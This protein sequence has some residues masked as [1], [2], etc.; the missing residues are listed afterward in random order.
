MTIRKAPRPVKR[1]AAPAA[2]QAALPTLVDELSADQR[3]SL[4]L[5]ALRAHDDVPDQPGDRLARRAALAAYTHAEDEPDLAIAW[6]LERRWLPIARD[7]LREVLALG[8]AAFDLEGDR[9]PRIAHVLRDAM[10]Q[11]PELQTFESFVEQFAATESCQ[12]F[13][14]HGPAR[15][16]FATAWALRLALEIR[17]DKSPCP[18]LPDC[19]VEPIAM[20]LANRFT[21]REMSDG[22]VVV[23]GGREIGVLTPHQGASRDWLKKNVEQIASVHAHRLLRF[24][25]ASAWAQDAVDRAVDP[26]RVAIDGGWRGVARALGVDGGK[27]ADEIHDVARVLGALRLQT[28]LGIEPVL[29][30]SS[31]RRTVP[32]L[33]G[34]SELRRTTTIHL[35]LLGPL[36]RRYVDALRRKVARNWLVPVP[37]FLPL[38]GGTKAQAAQSSLYLLVLQ[39]LRHRVETID[40]EERTIEIDGATVEALGARVG[41]SAAA[42]RNAFR[43]WCAPAERPFLEPVAHD[44]Y[45]INASCA[46]VEKHLLA[47]GALT[48]S[49]RARQ[50]RGR[51]RAGARD[52]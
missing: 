17:L 46:H 14:V 26:D 23:A 18:A 52:R 6:V 33:A 36:R 39:A 8:P 15:A 42:S 13:F 25:L 29:A 30:V 21:V 3:V 48:K 16:F 38:L 22:L 24:L 32:W 10:E 9:L 45:R 1:P 43:A 5:A 27:S 47:A 37:P 31:Q 44:R 50:R 20:L 49:A 51:G 4:A 2:S 19:I 7:Y 28:P 41:L 11:H 35:E 12:K 34:G 40:E